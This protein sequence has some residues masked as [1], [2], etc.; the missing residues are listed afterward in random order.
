[1]DFRPKFGR[2]SRS[3]AALVLLA[4]LAVVL[5]LSACGKNGNSLV[6]GKIN[7]VTTFY[8]LYYM[9][10]EIGG[11]DA[12]VVNL[13]PAGVEP[14]DW[15]PKSQDLQLASQ[16]QLFVYNG[17]GLEGWTEDFLGGAGSGDKLLKVE[18]SQGVKLIN[19]SGGETGEG[20]LSVDPHT[21]V[22][23]KSAVVMAGNIRDAFVKADAAHAA[24][25]ESRY[26]ALKDKLDAL[27]AEFAQ[28]LAPYRGRDIVVSHQAFGYL[29]RDYGLRQTAVMGLSPEAEP[30]AQDMVNIIKYIKEHKIKA[31][32]F[33]ELVSSNL[34]DTIASE[35]DA[36]TLV[37]NPLEGLTNEQE[38]AGEDYISLMKRNLQNLQKALQ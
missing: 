19:G 23:P 33:E 2:R 21:W 32:F 25:Y 13:V 28:G 37:L 15:T 9:A 20:G 35:T 27:D 34:A 1:M 5:S 17:A 30:R 36:Q 6:K 38:K 24:A 4:A 29:C 11:E 8:P 10:H 31:V 14:H 18:A 22:S 3:A 7:V 16:A 12:N 26:Q